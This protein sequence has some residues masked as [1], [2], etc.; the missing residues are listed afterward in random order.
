MQNKKDTIKKTFY[1]CKYLRKSTEEEDSRSIGNQNDVLDGVIENIIASDPY[2]D[3]IE[4]GTF[5]D[6]NYT[7]T[8]SDR[9]DFKKVLQ[10]MGQ[11]KINMILV[12]DLSRL[13]R[14]IAESINY[15][16]S[17]FVMLDIRFVSYQLPELDSYLNPDKIYS[18]EVPIQSM[19]N[20]NHCEETSLK[21]R[22]TF[23]RLREEGKFIGSFAAYGWEKD[24]KDR[25]KL[26]LDKEAYEVMHLMKDLL[27]QY[28]SGCAIATYLN[29]NGILSPA[30]HKKEKGYQHN[31]VNK[32]IT[33]EFLWSGSMVRKLLA[34]PENVGTLIQGRQKV[35]SY[36]IHKQVKVPKEQWYVTPN[37]MP[38]IFTK[39]EQKKIDKL[40][41]MNFREIDKKKKKLYMSDPAIG[42]D[43]KRKEPYL[44][45]GFLRCPDCGRAM[46]RKSD[47]KGYAYYI[48]GSYKNYGSCTK[49]SIKEEDLA[50]I[51][52]KAIQQQIDIAIEMDELVKSIQATPIMKKK[53]FDYQEQ[54][55]KQEKE[56]YK[57]A[58][59]KKGLYQDFKDGLISKNEYFNLKK[60]YTE[61]EERIQS[62]INSLNKELSDTERVIEQKDIYLDMFIKH[63]GFDKLNRDILLDLVKQIYVY[64]NK[65]VKI[66]FTFEDEYKN[67]IAFLEEGKKLIQDQ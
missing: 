15:I 22:R 6:E 19:M 10:L 53:T 17:L 46:N 25:H 45:S 56:L 1:Y 35:K 54:K 21:V 20:E 43:G 16:Q 23:N 14:N 63:K 3:Y 13:S 66:E 33:G 5:K 38:A 40:L 36:K 41:A 31:S 34:R 60:D 7:G 11:G 42:K 30:G 52:Y 49:H 29:E 27:F 51:V 55:S 65:D 58:H 62:A 39:D 50:E 44:F 4:V 32:N 8:D 2:N 59:Y 18:L 24:P 12:T 48:C 67:L 37:G 61:Q 57:I 64:E 26:I 47:T 28:N 9:P